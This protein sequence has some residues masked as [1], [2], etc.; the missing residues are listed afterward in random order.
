MTPERLALLRELVALNGGEALFRPSSIARTMACPGSIVAA[1][2]AP[3]DE[4][5]SPYAIEGSAAHKVGEDALN[6]VREP[7]DWLDRK[8]V[9][10]DGTG[11]F[12]DEEM[13][14]SV[15]FYVE[16]VRM[17]MA[18][19]E[20]ERAVEVKAS[21]AA[22]DPTDPLLAQNRGTIDCRLVDRRLRRLKIVD[23]KYGKGI[24]VAGDSPQLQN[25][26]ALAFT[27]IPV[28]GGWDEV[29]TIVV[30]PRSKE[31]I[32]VGPDGVERDMR[33]KRATFTPYDLIFGFL[34]R[35]IEAMEE[36]L[37][38]HAR[39]SPGEHCRFCPAKAGCPALADRA[40]HLARDAFAAT[41]LFD[42]SSPVAAVPVRVIAAPPNYA[43]TP[44]IMPPGTVLLP[45]PLSMDPADLATILDRRELYD[46]FMEGVER[47]AAQ[48]LQAGVSVPGYAMKAR[49]GNRKWRDPEQVPI[50]LVAL[51]LKANDIYAPPRL[52]SPKQV[53]DMLPATHRGPL[54]AG[55]ALTVRESG[56]PTL[57]KADAIRAIL[58]TGLGPLTKPP[59]A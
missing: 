40:F 22:L 30:Q 29:E 3:R 39:L 34:P 38:P 58:P 47:R 20:W 46:A 8:V 1:A 49:T 19:G 41:P 5:S 35:L 57:V 11:W 28:E 53:E 45:S 9:L 55:G 31:G 52:K 13:V 48:F 17:L 24:M 2:R 6:N 16:T 36:S 12:V 21:L 56:E 26:A 7:T 14:E 15:G 32:V 33:V 10:P 4:R 25:Y 59:G 43:A 37:D 44:A 27:S 42:A 23:L 51:G 18:G 54:A 50:A